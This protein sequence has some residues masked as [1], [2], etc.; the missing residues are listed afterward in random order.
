SVVM[1]DALFPQLERAYVRT[2]AICSS[3]NVSPQACITL[4]YD[5]PF[6]VIGPCN[7][8]KTIRIGTSGLFTN[9]S[10][11]ASGGQDPGIPCPF[12]WWQAAQVLYTS[13][14]FTFAPP[15]AAGLAAA[16]VSFHITSL[17]ARAASE[18][19]SVSRESAPPQAA[20]PRVA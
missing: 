1:A 9:H 3:E 20:T 5:C 16:M 11:P 19:R 2:A 8:C 6:T 18:A 15:G 4:L 17:G 14:P 12:C 7:P 10:E 13:A